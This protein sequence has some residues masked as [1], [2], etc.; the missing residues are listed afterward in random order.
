MTKTLYLGIIL[1]LLGC[2]ERES[3]LEQRI[4]RALSIELSRGYIN[5]EEIELHLLELFPLGETK[6]R[7]VAKLSSR[8][9]GTI[10]GTTLD[11]EES[12]YVSCA[13]LGVDSDGI[14]EAVYCD[15]SFDDNQLLLGV[16]V[17]YASPV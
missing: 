15:F 9:V 11:L 5:C 16:R 6:D 3:M 12:G 7:V 14:K 4:E 2:S 13:F 10:E 8:G 17:Y 1:L